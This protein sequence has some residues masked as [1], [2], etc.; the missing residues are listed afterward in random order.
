MS[1]LIAFLFCILPAVAFSQ[2]SRASGD[3]RLSLDVPFLSSG[4]PVRDRA[5]TITR[6]DKRIL[7]TSSGGSYTCLYLNTRNGDKAVSIDH[8]GSSCRDPLKVNDEK[9][10]LMLFTQSGEV[11]SFYNRKKNGRIEHFVVSGGTEL[12]PV[13]YLPDTGVLERRGEAV[14]FFRHDYTAHPYRANTAGA[15]TFYLVGERTPERL[16]VQKSL[17]YS[18]IGFLKTDNG[19]FMSFRIEKGDTYFNVQSWEN[20]ATAFDKA[21]FRLVEA[22]LSYEFREYYAREMR[23][24]E[25]KTFSGDCRDSESALNELRKQ[26]LRRQKEAV[27]R[28]K[29]GNVYQDPA[30]VGAYSDLVDPAF[31]LES[32]D[33]D[34]QVKICKAE[35]QRSRS[36]SE[37]TV[38]RLSEKIRCLNN[39]RLDIG[40]VKMEMDALDQRY[41]GHPERGLPEKQRLLGTLMG[42]TCN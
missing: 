24:L 16:T 23:K 40:R 12:A 7:I 32:F 14:D 34:T 31:Q 19:I 33:M 18:G 39:L 25:S 22:Q 2:P 10:T 11:L 42:R 8:D 36:R 17:S 4:S 3:R 20:V 38:E 13:N 27:E 28:T 1:K 5:T 35:A 9:F 41:R 15:P 6:F 26:D 29:T 30:V 37:R 21:P